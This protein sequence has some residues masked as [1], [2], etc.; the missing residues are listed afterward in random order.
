MITNQGG[1][2]DRGKEGQATLT[3]PLSI[4]IE[5]PVKAFGVAMNDIRTWLDAHRIQPADF[6]PDPAGPGTVAFEIRF[7]REQEARLF[8]Q[9]FRVTGRSIKLAGR[10]A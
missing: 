3:S 7:H 1:A 5:S 9:A 4:R 10:N 6:K 8:E 2:T